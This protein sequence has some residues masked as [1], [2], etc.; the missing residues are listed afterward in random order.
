MPM[1][2]TVGLTEQQK[3]TVDDLQAYMNKKYPGHVSKGE[4][5]D[6]VA[7][8]YLQGHGDYK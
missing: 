5:I 3:A 6:H 8:E 2:T 7:K 4:A 1:D